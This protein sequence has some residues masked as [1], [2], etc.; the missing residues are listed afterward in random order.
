MWGAD[1]PLKNMV[2]ASMTKEDSYGFLSQA[3]A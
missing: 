3:L 1:K 2:E